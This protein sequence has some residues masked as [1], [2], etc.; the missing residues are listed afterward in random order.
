MIPDKSKKTFPNQKRECLF[1]IAAHCFNVA[2]MGKIFY[3]LKPFAR[4]ASIT[5]PSISALVDET[6]WRR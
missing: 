5:S 2:D 1:Y 3:T 6:G 4:I